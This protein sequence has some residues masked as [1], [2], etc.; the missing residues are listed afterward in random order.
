MQ[1]Y[2]MNIGHDESFSSHFEQGDL[3]LL[4][5]FSINDYLLNFDRNKLKFFHIIQKDFF[6]I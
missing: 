1:W 2:S 4:P 6:K 5:F 3:F